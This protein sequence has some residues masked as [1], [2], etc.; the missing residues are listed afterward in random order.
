LHQTA[1]IASSVPDIFVEGGPLKREEVKIEAIKEEPKKHGKTHLELKSTKHSHIHLFDAFCENP[2]NIKLAEKLEHEEVLL[3]LRKHFVTNFPWM[4]K[5]LVFALIPFLVY[6]LSTIGFLPL[7]LLPLE[8]IVLITLAYYFLIAEYI[9]TSYL[10]WFYNISL[11]TTERIL[12]L[13]FSSI[14]FENVAATKLTLVEDVTYDRVG[15]IRSFFDYGDVIVQTAG[16]QNE[17]D[18]LAVPHPERVIK[19]INS[20]TGLHR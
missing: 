15:V 1:I 7:D 18:F 10:T 12:D 6:F 5:T 2:P 19:I 4:I 9:F 11:V 14:V 20:L 8:Y 17:F 13:D 16:T 3:F